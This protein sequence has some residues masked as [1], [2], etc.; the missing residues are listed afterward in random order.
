MNKI[1]FQR[2][3]G[4]RVEIKD[5]I[6]EYPLDT[7][8]FSWRACRD[9]DGLDT[10]SSFYII[11]GIT[12]D[13][14]NEYRTSNMFANF[15]F[16]ETGTYYI[17]CKVMYDNWITCT[18]SIEV[19]VDADAQINCDYT[20]NY[21]PC[22]NSSETGTTLRIDGIVSNVQNVSKILVTILDAGAA[23]LPQ[24]TSSREYDVISGGVFEFNIK[25]IQSF[26]NKSVAVRLSFQS[27]NSSGVLIEGS[28]K[29]KEI[30]LLPAPIDLSWSASDLPKRSNEFH[31]S[32]Y[33]TNVAKFTWM[34]NHIDTYYYNNDPQFTSIE[35][36]RHILYNFEL[37][38]M[39][40]NNVIN[41][42]DWPDVPIFQKFLTDPTIRIINNIVDN[43][44]ALFN[45]IITEDDI[46][47]DLGS[48]E[49]M[50]YVWK[51]VIKNSKCGC[52]EGTSIINFSY[53]KDFIIKGSPCL[54]AIPH[55]EINVTII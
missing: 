13:N 25:I 41:A 22:V 11:N 55:N 12:P 33:N 37:G 49:S 29:I 8:L 30:I 44:Q 6:G 38:D 23:L 4:K 31:T 16:L 15:V 28:Y 53:D 36:Y 24:L 45:L 42:I 27:I 35:I 20:L 32:T 47:H 40:I 19:Q 5:L 43:K 1:I 10:D 52:T 26:I 17:F 50:A 3:T 7:S 2:N 48:N 14:T 39:T 18:Y 21:D 9:I 51:I 54:Q 34:I 46:L